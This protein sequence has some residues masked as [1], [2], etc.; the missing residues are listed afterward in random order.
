[1]D[2]Y[3]SDVAQGKR[4]EFGKNWNRFLAVLT[5][6]RISEAEKSLK[7]MLGVVDLKGKSF[8]DIGSGSGLFSLAARR[9]GARVH[10]FDFDPHSVACTRE[11]KRRYFSDDSMWIVE[12]GSALDK[13]YVASLGSFDI[14]YSWGVLHHTGFMWDGLKNV[15]IPLASSGKLFIALYNDQGVK[16]LLWLGV[17][18]FYC[19]SVIGKAVVI[20]LFIP[21]FIFGGLIVDILRF[22]SP[23][24]RYLDYKKTRGMS[25]VHDWIDWLG[26]Y[27]F[28]VAKPDEVIEFFEAKGF[29]LSNQRCCGN[30]LGCNEFVF[31]KMP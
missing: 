30:K 29:L 14:V 22:R 3:T 13:E 27:P 17:K 4:F 10:S 16:S 19:S 21:Y 11:L 12:R 25:P 8:L 28:E 20:A 2:K 7:G 24:R 5:D 31:E 6:E 18:R 15:Q 26:G 9:L 23:L 1:M